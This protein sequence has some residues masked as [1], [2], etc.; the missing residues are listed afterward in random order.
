MKKRLFGALLAAVLAI[1]C[2]PGVVHATSSNFLDYTFKGAGY[3]ETNYNGRNLVAKIDTYFY[4]NLRDDQYCACDTYF[5]ERNSAGV[6]LNTR[7]YGYTY[8]QFEKRNKVYAS[9]GM[10]LGYENVEAWSSECNAFNFATPHYYGCAL[11]T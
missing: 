3:V 7:V 9:S 1:T 8:A 6:K 4:E 2:F 5:Y 10:Q 11:R